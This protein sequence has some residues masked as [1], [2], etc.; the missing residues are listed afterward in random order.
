M[1]V[2]QPAGPLP[3]TPPSTNTTPPLRPHP[4]LQTNAPIQIRIQ[5]QDQARVLTVGL[6]QVTPR[7]L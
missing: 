5:I 3:A 7:T 4:L 6:F 1:W 2:E